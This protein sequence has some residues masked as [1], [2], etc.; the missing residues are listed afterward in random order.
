MRVSRLDSP[1]SLS[2][3]EDKGRHRGSWLYYSKAE[4]GCRDGER[5]NDALLN[6]KNSIEG[7]QND[8]KTTVFVRLGALSRYFYRAS[9]HEQVS[10][11]LLKCSKKRLFQRDKITFS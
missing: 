7:V 8:K 5:A 10:F 9:V 6:V 11:T 1:G 2:S 3:R 4:K